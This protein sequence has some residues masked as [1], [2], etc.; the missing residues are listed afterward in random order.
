[1]DTQLIALSEAA[2]RLGV[3]VATIR[4]LI[5]RGEVIAVNV[6]SRRLVPVSE[7]D[8]IAQRGVGQAR[9]IGS[10]RRRSGDGRKHTSASFA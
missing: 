8:R 1:M 2:R 5:A 10:E 4:R 7:I 3:S 9:V 6:G